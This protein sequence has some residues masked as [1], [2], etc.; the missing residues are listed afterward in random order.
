[1]TSTIEI[2]ISCKNLLERDFF[3]SLSDPMCVVYTRPW[4]SG[5]WEEYMRTEVVWDNLNPEF[6]TKVKFEY[7]FEEQQSIRF[8]VYDIDKPSR[9]LM[10]QGFLGFA[11]CTIGRIVSAGYGGL[12]LKL[13]QNLGL[14]YLADSP[15]GKI[16]GSI[17]LVAEKLVE[18][19]EEFLQKFLVKILKTQ[20]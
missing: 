12:E 15:R 14:K 3:F 6:A 1:P 2:S 11:E 17:I 16:Q 10:D 19:K 5:Q 18:S 20:N 7:W 8:M 13:S 9:N 4:T